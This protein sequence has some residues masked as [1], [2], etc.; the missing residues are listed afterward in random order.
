MKVLLGVL[1]V[2]LAITQLIVLAA[3]QEPPQSK[4]ITDR[5]TLNESSVDRSWPDNAGNQ[6]PAMPRAAK[7]KRWELVLGLVAVGA[8]LV[9]GLFRWQ[10]RTS[11]RSL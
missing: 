4:V 6:G 9:Y 1:C 8:L 2:A 5:S 7:R 11:R 10:A 3:A